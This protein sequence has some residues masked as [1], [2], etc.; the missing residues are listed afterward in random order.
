MAIVSVIVLPAF[1]SIPLHIINVV[2][3][4]TTVNDSFFQNTFK[5]F[6]LYVSTPIMYSAYC[7]STDKCPVIVI[8]K[9]LAPVTNPVLLHAIF[10]V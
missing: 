4:F 2:T 7:D 1:M 9:A 3:K 8:A 6:L 5:V 10:S